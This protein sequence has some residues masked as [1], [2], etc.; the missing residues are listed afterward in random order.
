MGWV[1]V[2]ALKAR[3]VRTAT[4]PVAHSSNPF[5]PFKNTG[6]VMLDLNGRIAYAS[7]YF[8][9]MIGVAYDKIAGM[10]CFDSRVH[11]T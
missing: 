2:Q 11:P 5:M 6:L 1:G 4:I 3:E 9:D 8:C 7:T 10:S